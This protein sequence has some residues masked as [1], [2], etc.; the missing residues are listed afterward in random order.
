MISF[1]VVHYTTISIF[2][3]I[4]AESET[5]LHENKAENGLKAEQPKL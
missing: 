5:V 1:T 2:Q 4:R 3:Y